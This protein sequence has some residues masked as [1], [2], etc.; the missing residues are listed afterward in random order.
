MYWL[1]ELQLG[2]GSLGQAKLDQLDPIHRGLLGFWPFNDGRGA[3]ARDLTG[4]H[5]QAAIVNSL[6]S[7]YVW[8][9]GPVLSTQCVRFD[10]VQGY[11]D[12]GNITATIIGL[13]TLCIA[14]A[15]RTTTTAE[16]IPFGFY[17]GFTTNTA[18]FYVYFNYPSAG[19]IS[20]FSRNFESGV[21]RD[22]TG[23]I[24]ATFSDGNWHTLIIGVT[25]STQTIVAMLDAVPYTVTYTAQ[26]TTAPYTT[27]TNG[28]IIGA[29]NDN[30]VV[31]FFFPGDMADLRMFARIPSLGEAR[32]I[33]QNPLTGVIFPEE[34]SMF[35]ALPGSVFVPTDVLFAQICM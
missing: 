29:L 25:L 3:S 11:S 12:P 33:A 24:T 18:N 32:R 22:T 19:K 7:P 35:G 8:G 5:S 30:G 2:P 31:D 21:N 13:D 15:F 9:P 27:F 14:F 10:G 17:N 20:L 16:A 26:A 1:S 28:P 34:L 6:Y 4:F 23:N